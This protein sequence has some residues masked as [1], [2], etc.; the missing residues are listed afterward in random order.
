MHKALESGEQPATLRQLALGAAVQEG[1]GLPRQKRESSQIPLNPPH[2][3]LGILGAPTSH[4]ETADHFLQ[5]DIISLI[6][7]VPDAAVMVPEHSLISQPFKIYKHVVNKLEV[8]AWLRGKGFF[9]DSVIISKQGISGF[10]SHKGEVAFKS[11]TLQ[12]NSGWWQVSGRLMS[13]LEA[14]DPLNKG[15]PYVNESSQN[16]SRNVAMRFYGVTPATSP[17]EAQALV[18][19]T[20]AGWPALSTAQTRSRQLALERGKRDIDQQDD[21][22]NLA[23][24]LEDAAKGLV[25]SERLALSD[26]DFEVS[27][28]NP[29]KNDDDARARLDAFVARPEVRAIIKEM[30]EN[31]PDQPLRVYEGKLQV[32]QP[33]SQKWQDVPDGEGWTPVLKTELAAI[34]ELTKKLGNALYTEERHDL[35]QVAISM[36]LGPIEKAGEARAAANWLRTRFAPPASIGNYATLLPQEWAPGSLSDA[37][38]QTLAALATDQKY[39]ANTIGTV[40][41]R[42]IV[43]DVDPGQAASKAEEIWVQL[44]NTPEA[45]AWGKE[46]ANAVGWYK[47][48]VNWE[49][50]A[51]DQKKLVAATIMLSV[52]SNVPGVPGTA[53]GYNFY[54]PKNMGRELGSIRK[55]F[56]KYL[57]EK[58]GVSA[59]A[60]PLVAHLFLAHAA[61]EFLVKPDLQQL[62]KTPGPL[63]VPVDQIRLGSPAWMTLALGS[64]L[65]EVWGGA[66]SS[67]G[68]NVNELGA[69]TKLEGVLPEHKAL[70]VAL[71]TRVSLQMGVMSGSV[72][73]RPD[74]K[75]TPE[76]YR[77]ATQGITQ[78]NTVV[79]HS[80]K[81]LGTAPPTRTSLA[82][83]ALKEAFPELTGA[84]LETITLR[85]PATKFTQWGQGTNAKRPT[86]LEA[87]AT[88]DLHEGWFGFSH[89]HVTQAQFESR[90][91]SL[92]KIADQVT[93]AVDRYLHDVKGAMP[94]LMK[95]TLAN[96]PLEDRQALEW[97]TVSVY[98]LRRETGESQPQDA[99]KGNKVA[100]NRG[101]HGVLL[102]SE[103]EG[104]KRYY[105]YFPTS[106]TVINR[107][108][109]LS[110]S[111]LKLDGRIQT[112]N[113]SVGRF[114]TKR[115]RYLRGSSQPFDFEAYLTG[116]PPRPGY[117]SNAILS[118]VGTSLAASATK[119][120]GEKPEDWVPDT[121]NSAKTQAIIDTILHGNYIGNYSGHRK[122]LISHANAVLPSEDTARGYID[123]LM[124]KENGRALVSMISF[125]GPIVSMIEGDVKDG[126]KGLLIDVMSFAG[127]GGLQAGYKAWKAVRLASGLNGQMFRS[128][129]NTEGTAL[130]RGIFNPAEGFLG[131]ASQPGNLL[132]FLQR[133][134]KGVPTKVGMGIFVPA[135]VFEKA[136]FI[137]DSTPVFSEMLRAA[138]ATPPKVQ[139]TVSQVTLEAIQED[140]QWY[141]IDPRSDQPFGA[142]L[143][144]FVPAAA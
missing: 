55:D 123:R 125:V 12:D 4:A 96:L 40:M 8:M 9:L 99:A 104:K 89:P 20:E 56:E 60:A 140:G 21:R 53:A 50:S 71:G 28:T 69:L 141:A 117:T 29:L 18:T 61:P 88:G 49:V 15:V 91:K 14:L 54:A 43:T 87:Y 132:K 64:A 17:R 72:T 30:A 37:N 74:G 114:N 19:A 42:R 94:G 77:K 84:E 11:Y 101:W 23:D 102:C 128:A 115:V 44:L 138:S 16:I 126:F 103:Y 47:K 31:L 107:T 34:S 111:D 26:I 129:L 78:S 24:A 121:F 36:N 46:L 48:G 143:V 135:D 41:G 92:P 10:V 112:V 85:K 22:D 119:G 1:A 133:T 97:G 51:L 6:S 13:V 120:H 86:L 3:T 73:P 127:T 113:E 110:R 45:Q 59:R 66:G 32:L 137:Q 106:G 5:T 131:L 118:K 62:A 130:L 65:A 2:R 144:G 7:G 136:R 76:D 25:D 122:E 90:I 33:I 124:T 52:D 134:R 116:Q 98:R 38:K 95:M 68:M 142:P 35:R 39:G 70:A 82:I 108:A 67:R 83:K 75:Y 27:R 79:E 80:I 57:T 63:R 58:K 100:E 105:E 109:D 139:G 93:G 81:T